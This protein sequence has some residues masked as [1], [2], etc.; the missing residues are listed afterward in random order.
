MHSP[1]LALSWELWRPGRTALAVYLAVYL[2]LG[3]LFLV[4]PAEAVDPKAAV[5]ISLIFLAWL[6]AF[7]L[8]IFTYASP[9]ADLASV[10]S[11]FP[12]RLFTLP[13][14]TQVLVG[15]P[16]L[17]GTVLVA[18]TWVAT[19]LVLASRG[20]TLP[21]W[22]PAL[23]LAAFVAWFQALAWCPFGLPW[24]RV[25]VAVLFLGALVAVPQWIRAQGVPEEYLSAA[26]AGLI[27]LAYG[28]A[29]VGVSRAR[30]GDDM[31]WWPSRAAA[32]DVSRQAAH[33]G[34]S[35]SSAARAQVWYEWRRH[36]RELPFTTLLLLA[37]FILGLVVGTHPGFEMAFRALE[38][39]GVPPQLPTNLISLLVLVPFVAGIAGVGLG[40]T[41]ARDFAL[42]AFQ[43]TRPIPTSALVAAKLKAAAWITLV[44]WGLVGVVA[45]VALLGFGAW[46]A[47]LGWVLDWL[48]EQSPLKAGAFV[49]VVAVCFIGGTWANLA[50]SV[51]L[52]L[53]G[54]AWIVYTCAAI[55]AVL[56]IAAVMLAQGA[57]HHPE[58]RDVLESLL[59]WA[60]AGLVLLKIATVACVTRAVRRKRLIADRVI[61]VAVGIWV[62]LAASLFGLIQWL[63]PAG[64]V[65]WYVIACGVML[66]MPLTRMLAAPL[67]LAWNRHR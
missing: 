25:A 20:I 61:V 6:L 63:V 44:S 7:A 37:M 42:P 22:W 41:G 57:V 5:G 48:G 3:V 21:L 65:P 9:Q 17:H 60:L 46:E 13:V 64:L 8:T 53:L 47:S 16:M 56:S 67:A 49:V 1:A 50:G 27:P 36:G 52:G 58:N 31:S 59:P 35:F 11:L 32:S 12:A 4:L 43:A 54:R 26:F 51:F 15:W 39:E 23:G 24:L 62:V 45:P 29:L 14:R 10:R 18:G 2:I 38:K 30:R 34:R 66:L 28:A 40:N 55:A 33:R 19:V